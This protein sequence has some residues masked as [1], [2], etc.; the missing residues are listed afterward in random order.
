MGDRTASWPHFKNDW[1]L[2][3]SVKKHWLKQI[4]FK[5]KNDKMVHYI[6]LHGFSVRKPRLFGFFG[7][8]PK[9]VFWGKKK[10]RQGESRI[11]RYHYIKPKTSFSILLVFPLADSL[12]WSVPHVFFHQTKTATREI[13]MKSCDHYIKPKKRSFAFLAFF[14]SDG[15]LSSPPRVFSSKIL[16]QKGNHDENPWPLHVTKMQ[17][18]LAFTGVSLLA[19]LFW[20]NYS[21]PPFTDCFFCENGIFLGTES[22]S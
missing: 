5:K 7:P 6:A 15:F 16:G 10:P 19:P 11:N 8:P 1:S 20:R 4:L 13:T 14:L 3:A 17:W 21:R 22:T 9:S 2:R 18:L 12:F